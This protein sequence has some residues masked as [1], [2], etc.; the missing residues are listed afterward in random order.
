[1]TR[2][3]D[4]TKSVYDLTEE[5]PQ[6]ID[7]LKDL[8]FLGLANPVTR[9]TIGKVTTIPQGCKLQG[10]DLREVIQHLKAQGFEVTGDKPLT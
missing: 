4:L 10:K 8:G 9:S 2:A 6:L 3:I 5:H 7:T 1:M